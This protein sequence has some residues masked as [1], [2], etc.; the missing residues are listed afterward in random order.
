MP[1]TILLITLLLMSAFFSSAE[2]GFIYLSENILITTSNEKR[3]MKFQ[4]LLQCKNSILSTTLL[5]NNLSNAAFAS[6]SVIA[7]SEALKSANVNTA[8]VITISS[9]ASSVVLFVFGELIPKFFALKQEKFV[10]LISGNIMLFLSRV[11]F[12][13]SF[14]ANWIIKILG[15]IF[16][17][18]TK[19]QDAKEELRNVLLLRHQQGKVKTQDR[20]MINGILELQ[21][22]DV[23]D[24]ITPKSEVC[25]VDISNIEELKNTI[26]KAPYT[27]FPVINTAKKDSDEVVGVIHSKDLLAL[28]LQKPE[29]TQQDIAAIISEPVLIPETR[30]LQKQLSYF[31]SNKQHL[32]LAVNEFGD[33]V[34]IVTLEDILEEIVGDIDDEH[35]HA[36]NDLIESSSGAILVAGDYRVRDFNKEIGT[37]FDDEEFT[38]MAGLVIGKAEKIPMK[39]ESF[40][41][42]GYNFNVKQRTKSK[43]TQI[44]I[45]K[46][47]QV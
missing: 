15:K 39:N 29:V 33:I 9:I 8:Y 31:Q 28:T 44:E 21:D 23:R 24:I 1:S 11:F 30:N 45:N 10:L 27:R 40:V 36:E 32:A 25:F 42:D 16:Q 22:A 34:G 18:K 5:L 20:N 7:V 41:I 6:A 46:S 2:V 43:I 19:H 17:D 35:D 37:N 26:A 3:R 12:P 13:V 4:K 38:T 47:D 14:S